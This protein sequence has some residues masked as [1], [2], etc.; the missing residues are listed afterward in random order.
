M[1]VRIG[2][3]L[4][5]II[6]G[7]TGL[8]SA[9]VPSEAPRGA[10]VSKKVPSA[11]VI[12][13]STPKLPETLSGMIGLAL[14][15]NPDISLAVARLREAEAELNQARLRVTQEVVT[16]HQQYEISGSRLKRAQTLFESGQ[17]DQDTMLERKQ[18]QVRLEAKLRYLVGVGSDLPS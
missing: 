5:A 12:K 2:S 13:A 18:E 3:W 6:V 17:A 16:T 4:I 14:R 8:A 7:L 1:M 10:P 11:A 9:Q 15:S